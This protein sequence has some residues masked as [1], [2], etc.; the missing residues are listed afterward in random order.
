VSSLEQRVAQ[1]EQEVAA[2]QESSQGEQLIPNYL[3]VSPSGVISA[4]FPGGVQMEE[5]TAATYNAGQALGWLDSAGGGEIREFILG[6]F[7][8]GG[9]QLNLVSEADANDEASIFVFSKV[10]GAAGSATVNASAADSSGA[11]AELT[12]LDSLARS[13]FL[14]LGAGVEALA[15]TIGSVEQTVGAGV[16]FPIAHGLPRTPQFAGAFPLGWA[17]YLY[18][19]SAADAIN[20]HLAASVALANNF[21]VWVAIG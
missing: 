1:L 4:V 7:V 17:G 16:S 14:Q 20:L 12:V 19:A 15:I 18:N 3:T 21:L 11:N 5:E 9:H 6:A 2:L 8:F 10:A 13:A